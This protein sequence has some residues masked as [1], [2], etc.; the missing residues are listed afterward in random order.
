MKASGGQ[1]GIH[2][3]GSWSWTCWAKAGSKVRRAT[4]LV[5]GGFRPLRVR[6]LPDRSVAPSFQRWGVTAVIPGPFFRESLFSAPK[7]GLTAQDG[8]L[9]YAA[10]RLGRPALP[11]PNRG[12]GCGSLTSTQC[13][14]TA[15][16]TWG[17]GGLQSTPF[18]RKSE[19]SA[20]QP[21]RS[22]ARCETVRRPLEGAVGGRD[23]L[24]VLI[25][26]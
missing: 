6:W 20:A 19:S 4:P 7:R 3:A 12:R 13:A 18:A 16:R 11:E 9:Q 8:V 5:R 1:G 15:V 22:A 23:F 24:H 21:A 14:T 10:R 25:C 2:F 17:G 26:R